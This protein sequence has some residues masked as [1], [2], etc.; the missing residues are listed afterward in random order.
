MKAIR[1]FDYVLAAIMTV[2]GSALM[3]LNITADPGDSSLAHPLTSQS[4]LMLPLFLLV[5]VPILGRRHS[6]V[7]VAWITAVATA[8][9]VLAFGWVT[10]CGL[11]LPLAAALAYAVA[12]FGGS[13]R[14]Q[15]AALVGVLALQL[16]TLTRDA[17]IGTEIVGALPIALLGAA[18]LY[19][20]GVIVQNRASRRAVAATPPVGGTA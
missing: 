17:S 14:N 8:V 20:V 10:R 12:R 5:T 2:V 18:L 19:G 15:L 11:V 16:V 6:I 3:Y 13:W 9:H 7:A 4:W 1:P